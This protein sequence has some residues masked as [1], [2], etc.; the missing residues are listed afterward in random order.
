MVHAEARAGGPDKAGQP[1]S[2]FSRI[3]ALT[4]DVF[5]TTVDWCSGVARETE[6]MLK[7]KGYSLDWVRFANDWRRQYQP[8]MEAVRSGARGFVTMDV[9]HREMLEA[10]LAQYGITGLTEAEKLELTEAWRKLDPWPDVL[11]GMARLRKR[12]TLACV[13]NANI[14]LAVA[15]AKRAGLPWDVILGAEFARTYKTRP[16]IYDRT[17]EALRLEPGETMMVA[18]HVWDLDAAKA[19]GLKTAFVSRPD[20]YG[21]GKSGPASAEGSYDV[22]VNSFVE[23]AERL[24]A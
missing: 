18:C 9:L 17:V 21:P 24:G 15:M 11:E 4:F 23:L 5:G 22:V 3:K 14:A 7:P 19:R 16:E 6:A 8:A 12:F 2:D 20:E 1:V 13:S 10:P